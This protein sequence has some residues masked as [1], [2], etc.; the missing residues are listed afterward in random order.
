MPG[1]GTPPF[2]NK[3]ATR[4]GHLRKVRSE[5][6]ASQ[7][8]HTLR[9]L[10]IDGF[11]GKGGEED[12]NHR[13]GKLETL[14]DNAPDVIFRVDRN[15]RF[16]T[17]NQ[18]LSDLTG[19]QKEGFYG[20]T[21]LQ[22]GLPKNLCLFLGE[23]ARE[24]V[25]RRGPGEFEFAFE[26]REGRKWHHL[27]LVP[28]TDTQGNVETVLGI[29]H[30]IT[31]LRQAE[32]AYRKELAFR[33]S[34]ESCLLSGIMAI[35]LEGLITYVNPAFC[36]M[37]GWSEGELVGTK[38]PYVFW[39]DEERE[40][41][42]EVLL[43]VLSGQRPPGVLELGF[44]RKNG[45]YLDVLMMFSELKD[46][47]GKTVGWVRSFNDIT[48]LKQKEWEVRRLNLE[49]EQRV[50]E[51]TARLEEANEFL[52]REIVQ[53]RRTEEALRE[54][55][56]RLAA[57]L[58][59]MARLHALAMLSVREENLQSVLREIVVTA[60]D[61]AAASFGNIQLLDPDSGDLKI[62][63]QCGFPQWWIDFWDSVYK[64]RGACGTALERGERVIVE[65]VEQSPIFANTGALEIQLRA[66]VRAVQSTP[67][68]SRSGRVLGMFST[69]YKTRHR[70]DERTLRLL[71]LLARQAADLIERMENEQALRE[72]EERFRTL[73]MAG[74]DVVYCMSPDWSEMRQLRGGEFVTDTEK[75]SRH[76]LEKYIHPD[77]RE[78]VTSVINEAVLT[79]SIFELEHR[80]VRTDGSLGW[81]FSRAV[82][83]L[84]AKGNILEWFG[85]ASDVTD[86]RKAAELRRVLGSIHF[87]LSSGDEHDEIMQNVLEESAKALNCDTAAIS[88]KTD[89][90]WTV[91][92][93]YGFPRELVGT[94]MSDK[95][96]PHAL[97]ALHTGD[98]MAIEDAYH[99]ERVNRKRMKR[100]G[101][102]SVLVVPILKGTVGLGVFFFNYHTVP[103]RFTP[104]YL[105]FSR[106][107]AAAVSLALQ[108]SAVIEELKARTRQ[109][110]RANTELEAFAYT[111][112]HDLRNP[113]VATRGFCQRLLDRHGDQL[114]E[115]GS[116]YL[117][118]IDEGCQA[119]ERLIEGLLTLSRLSRT[120]VKYTLVDLSR[121]ARSI[122]EDLR[123]ID[124][125]R[126]VTFV[127]GDDLKTLG[128]PALLRVALQNLLSNAWKFTGK[129]AEAVIEFG[130]SNMEGICAAVY[131]VRDNGCGFDMAFADKIFKPFHRFHSQEEFPGTGIGLASAW[132][133]VERH[134][135]RIW[136]ESALDEGTT[137]FF[138]LPP[139]TKGS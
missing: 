35:D 110:E 70:P 109:L 38:P 121:L 45:E 113:L 34:I 115:K 69:H 55:D 127:V 9:C 60:I 120:V 114:D 13:V 26:T 111:V 27:H 50:T 49:L 66:G 131:F 88:L 101:I 137:V 72:S 90:A 30:D 20:K 53:H 7:N 126:D 94:R 135:G 46:S 52:G 102:Q 6:R 51:R 44:K 75:P 4:V 125:Q 123:M 11:E 89:D 124:P 97:L 17:V 105:N 12:L 67:L 14:L 73:V 74:S 25:D 85:T 91:T 77:D 118:R 82:P 5:I 106:S 83:L 62:V 28:E 103:V 87:I 59:A 112:S 47:A 19:V 98:P 43:E 29:S 92:Y 104:P 10:A 56:R 37:V 24:V 16:L 22:L 107:L 81:M 21:L 31:Q 132:R 18:R 33:Q 65:D 80:V 119:M 95:E 61:I 100:Y 116:H 134:G 40:H 99:D 3:L 39:P 42:M 68:Q 79:K 93:V 122:A 136:A 64:G 139:T 48:R 130:S 23:K 71:D 58:N 63:A 57:D 32:S 41:N 86:R 1:R 138:T 78:E 129:Q 8:R 54:S 117:M 128:D 96:E 2:P 36:T 84:D 15:L 108:R 133:I 76:W